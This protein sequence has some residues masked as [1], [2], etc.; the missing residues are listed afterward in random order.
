MQKKVIL[1]ENGISFEDLCNIVRNNYQLSLSDSVKK[2]VQLARKAIEKAVDSGQKI[3]GI[4]TGFGAL[5]DII[6]EEKDAAELQTNLIRSHCVGVGTP[7]PD[8]FVKAMMVL[9]IAALARGLSGVQLQTMEIKRL[10]L[11]GLRKALMTLVRIR[12]FLE[13]LMANTLMKK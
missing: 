6:I 10:N 1:D 7:A 4:T 9:R 2:K 5:R 8:E 11:F 3:Y 13:F 12:R